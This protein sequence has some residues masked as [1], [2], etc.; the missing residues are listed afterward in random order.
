MR[1]IAV[2]SSFMEEHHITRIQDTA[3]RCGF[4]ADFYPDDRLP[5]DKAV[6][7]EVLYGLVGPGFLKYM[8]GLKWLCTPS[9]GVEPYTPDEIYPSPDV[10]LT[11]SAGAYGI[12]ISEHILMVT[13]MLLRRMPDFQQ[14]VRERRW[15]RSMPMRSIC[16]STITVVGTGDIGT[17]F[18]R[19]AK[20]L[21]AKTIYGVRRTKKAADPCFDA[22]C[23][24]EELD[25]L[26][27]STDILV[28]ALPATAETVNVLSRQRIA[29][30]PRHAVVVNVGRGSAVDQDALM[31]ALND[32][33]IAGAALDV[34]VPEPLPVDHPLWESKNLII[35]P[36]ISGN[37]SL[38][39]TRDLDVE[40]FCGDLENY[41]AGRPLQHLVNRKLGY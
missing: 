20:A 23:T 7:Y 17:N 14:V 39:I 19:R 12:T 29:R 16:G 5:K 40:M 24:L 32:E 28:M 22:I 34:M 4:T 15:V 2:L 30:L 33:R 41:A 18:A 37:M 21:G 11:N 26:L 35:T 6:E 38:G 25:E 27:G 10:L 3:A 1:K 13:L 8:S 36:H 9:A 31:E